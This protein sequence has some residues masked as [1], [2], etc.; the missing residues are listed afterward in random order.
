SGIFSIAFE[1][2]F[3]GPLL[4]GDLPSLMTGM[5]TMLGD[6]APKMGR[7]STPVNLTLE[8]DTRFYDWKDLDAIDMSALI[9]ENISAILNSVG[10]GDKVV[11][12]DDIFPIKRALGSLA[13]K[14]GQIFEKDG[15]RYLNT[16]IAYYGGGLNLS[17]ASGYTDTAYNTYGPE[18]E[19]DLAYD[20]IEHCPGGLSSLLENAVLMAIGTHPFRFVINGAS[21]G[22]NPLVGLDGAPEIQT[23][24]DH[25]QGGNAS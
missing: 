2:A 5:L 22:K 3:N 8:G 10:Y 12:I 23:L 4:R 17:T 18:C 11:T 14:Q 16:A 1:S 21:E 25:I 7:T 9:D 24:K 6:L 20:A 13:S 15:K 19:I